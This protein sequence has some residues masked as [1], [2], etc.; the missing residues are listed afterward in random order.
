MTMSDPSFAPV[1]LD[2]DSVSGQVL[3][4]VA[5]FVVIRPSG[6][7]G[8]TVFEIL[9]ARDD[10]RIGD[11]VCGPLRKLGFQRIRAVR[12]GLLSRACVLLVDRDI[13]IVKQFLADNV[14]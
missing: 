1:F 14:S 3:D 6:S 10:F 4:V 11:T 7:E 13:T 2:A 8:L 5:S 12:T 9:G